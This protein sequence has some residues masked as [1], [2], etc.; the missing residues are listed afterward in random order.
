MDIA[1]VN[2]LFAVAELLLSFVQILVLA[3]IVVS[4]VGDPS[5]QIVQMIYSI[6]EPIYRPIRKLTNRI[7]GPLDWAPFAVIILVIFLSTVLQSLKRNML[8][9]GG[10]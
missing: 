8:M 5:N 4:W 10:F 9:Q 2:G 3:S 6:T 1:I 7:P